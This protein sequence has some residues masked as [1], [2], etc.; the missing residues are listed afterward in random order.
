MQQIHGGNSIKADNKLPEKFIALDK[1][2]ET[3]ANE[4]MPV[5]EMMMRQGGKDILTRVG[6][7]HEV[8]AVFDK[9]IPE[10]AKNASMKFAES[11]NQTTSMQLDEALTKLRGGISGGLVQGDTRLALRDRV[12]EVFDQADNDRA[13]TIADTEA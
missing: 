8:F 10:A 4:S 13:Q 1:W 9:N 7:S 11:T 3:I 2:N 5:V 6:A 12:Q